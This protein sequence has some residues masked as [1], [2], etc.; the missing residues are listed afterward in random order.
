MASSLQELI[1][2]VSPP[3]AR[4]P[5][6][7]LLSKT[8]LSTESLLLKEQ[9]SDV[10]K[11]SG[12]QEAL[13]IVEA[14]APSVGMAGFFS[15]FI[16]LV[17]TIMGAGMLS[18]PFGMSLVGLVPG[19][20]L[21][22]LA[23]VMSTFG[24]YLIVESSQVAGRGATFS[25]LA[26]MT[27]PGLA[28]FFEAVVAIKCLGVGISYLTIAS[29]LIPDIFKSFSTSVWPPLLSPLYWVFVVAGVIAPVT[30]M[31]KMDSL[32]YT[33]FLGLLSIA[34]MAILS[35]VLF[36]TLG[37]ASVSRISFFAPLKVSS[38]NALSIFIFALTCHQNIPSIQNEAKDRSTPAMMRIISASTATSVSVYILF[39][40]ASYATFGSAVKDNVIYSYPG[41]G[42]PYQVARFLYAFLMVFS[43]P[44]LT[45]PCRAA[46]LR[47]I[48]LVAPSV[49]SRLRSY[50]YWIVSFAILGIIMLVASFNLPLKLVLGYIGST[51]GP[52]ICFIL[53][54]LIY[55][56]LW[57]ARKVWNW[58]R[59][60]AL[61]LSGAGVIVMALLMTSLA[62]STSEAMQAYKKK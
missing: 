8:S 54:G 36:F 51:T 48:E 32:K 49:A 7:A 5:H 18:L 38:F 45:F 14:A 35:V 26:L 22:F 19:L 3:Y 1:P 41:H 40:L 21:L 58:R 43:L 30:L 37:S 28:I 62:F 44:L 57:Q 42:V 27:Y 59:I 11:A 2:Q 52:I 10:E 17:K 34:Y 15:S 25:S 46:S 20:G 16:N 60:A 24:V 33:S 23:T 12:S 6:H 47:L 39:A 56:K 4:K 9:T 53:P 29:N 50:L 61:S 13:Q 55:N 31:P